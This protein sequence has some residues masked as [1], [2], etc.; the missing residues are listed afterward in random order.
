MNN[1]EPVTRFKE[2]KTL[3]VIKGR[4]SFA[5]TI[6]SKSMPKKVTKITTI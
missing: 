2:R 6:L 3:L 1:I 5:P 4:S